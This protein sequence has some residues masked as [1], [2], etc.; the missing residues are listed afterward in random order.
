M[1]RERKIEILM[2]IYHF[3]YPILAATIYILSLYII[4]P[5]LFWKIGGILLLYLVPP[6]GKESMVPALTYIFSGIYG[7]WGILL[8]AV[9]ITLVDFFVSW[10]TAWNWDLLK[11]IPLV[12]RYVKKLER[13]G[14][15][16]W[17]DHP[18]IR[19][20]AYAG[21]AAFVA[22]PFQGS[23]G[24]TATIIGRLLGMN[25]YKVIASVVVGAF[26]GSMIIGSLAYFSIM[27]FRQWGFLTIGGIVIFVIVMV[28]VYMWLRGEKNENNGNGRS[29][30]HRESHS[31]SP[32]E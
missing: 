7:A 21:L 24:L 2:R 29:R 11:Y 32:D 13:I 15:K 31:G 1:D 19:K 3:L 8:A 6:A 30:L 20:F 23:G 26:V 17:R 28:V 18:V 25:E 9:L 27:S 4:F 5:T 10:W 14:E 16:K 12:G 22:I